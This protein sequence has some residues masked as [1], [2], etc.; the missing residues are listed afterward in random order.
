MRVLFWLLFM[1][2]CGGEHRSDGRHGDEDG[3]DEVEP[4]L[5]AAEL[6]ELGSVAESLVATGTLESEFQANLVPETSGVVTELYA[7]EGDWVEAGQLLAVLSNPSLQAG[8]DMADV[9]LAQALRELERV[10]ALH[11]DGVVS[12]REL[13]EARE[14]VETSR[15]NQKEASQTWA[16]SRITSPIAG[17]VSVRDVRLGELAGGARAFQIV[18]LARLQVAVQLPEKDLARVAVGQPVVLESA[19]DEE[20]RSNGQVARISPVVDAQMGTVKV[21]IR[22]D[23]SQQALRP[24][25]FVKARIEVGR[26]EGVLVVSRRT[27]V[28]KDGEP[29][30]WRLGELEPEEDED[31]GGDDGAEEGPGLWERL[32]G[33]D[34]EEEGGDDTGEEDAPIEPAGLAE[35]VSVEVGFQEPQKVEIR[36]GLVEGEQVI[37]IG[38][39]NLREGAPVR[40]PEPEDESGP[41]T[42]SGVETPPP[43]GEGSDEPSLDSSGSEPAEPGS[44]AAAEGPV[45]TNESTEDELE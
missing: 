29:Q 42:E 23:S 28:W 21:L 41:V 20:T 8:A 27:V 25:Q 14:A 31:T 19:Y 1:V 43:E 3:K 30:V 15:F 10:R 13:E 34:E 37:T 32:F 9:A 4:V 38:T 44:D 5:V 16:F 39:H 26:R 22:L 17:T 2:A 33:G 24:G 36:A 45:E 11:A 7:E 40:L 6:V 35:R 12:L 18:D